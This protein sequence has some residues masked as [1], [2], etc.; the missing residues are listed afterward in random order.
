MWMHWD[1]ICFLDFVLDFRVCTQ[2][3]LNR[4]LV[5]SP[6]PILPEEVLLS[7]HLRNICNDLNNKRAEVYLDSLNYL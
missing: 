3:L 7:V 2:L 4:N 5:T 1:H 6:Q